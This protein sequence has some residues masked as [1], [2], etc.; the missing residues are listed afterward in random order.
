MLHAES[1][2]HLALISTR[3]SLLRLPPTGPSAGT[4]LST[5]LTVPPVL[6]TL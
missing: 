1:W 3:S 4:V 6:T 5:F 2:E